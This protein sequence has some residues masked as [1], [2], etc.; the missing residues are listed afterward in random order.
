MVVIQWWYNV[1]FNVWAKQVKICWACVLRKRKRHYTINGCIGTL[2]FQQL[3]LKKRTRFKLKDTIPNF[4]VNGLFYFIFN[5]VRFYLYTVNSWSSL[6]DL[7]AVIKLVISMK[8]IF[9]YVNCS[10]LKQPPLSGSCSSGTVVYVQ[11]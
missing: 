1:F 10:T 3:I 4:M 8:K 7:S 6:C 2:L 11:Q 9:K 5:S